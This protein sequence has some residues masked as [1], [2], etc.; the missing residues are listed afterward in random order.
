MRPLHAQAPRCSTRFV[1]A[2]EADDDGAEASGAYRIPTSLEDA[3]ETRMCR[4]GGHGEPLVLVHPFALCNE[5][6]QPILPALEQHHE[7][8]ALSIPGHFGADP[9]PAD[10]EHSVEAGV[11]LLERK[12]DEKG[13]DKAHVVGNSLGG[14]FAIE[15]A[16]RGRALSVTALAPGGGWEEGSPAVDRLMRHFR[17]T[18]RLLRIGGELALKLVQFPAARYAFL[19]D[20]VARPHALTPEAA[21]LMIEAAYRCDA[22]EHVMNAIPTQALP[23]PF[24]EL[25][26]PVRLVWGAEDRLLPIEGFS[27]RWRR[28]LPGAEWLV[29]PNVGHVPMFD[30][31]DAVSNAILELTMRDRAEARLAG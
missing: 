27:E 10:Y 24:D 5:V 6:W 17:L 28:I 31:P 7:V 16:R 18:H 21:R 12:L 8:F 13:I 22:Y 11:D 26:C 2:H 29:L 1:D 25:P 4:C 9:L 20:C 14:W 15:L 3:R 19:R 23:M 30:D